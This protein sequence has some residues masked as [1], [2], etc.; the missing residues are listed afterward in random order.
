MKIKQFKFIVEK[1]I[2]PPCR[3]IVVQSE[4]GVDYDSTLESSSVA[5]APLEGATAVTEDGAAAG[6]NAGYNLYILA[7]HEAMQL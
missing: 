7:G 1:Y 4:V 6:E 5:P 2:L 3:T